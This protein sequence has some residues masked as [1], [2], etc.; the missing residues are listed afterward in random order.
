[1][2]I[3]THHEITRI[4]ELR[5]HLIRELQ[6]F[7][8]HYDE[9]E[10]KKLRIVGRARLRQARRR[11]RTGIRAVSRRAPM[12]SFGAKSLRIML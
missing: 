6:I 7:F 3:H 1:M 8:R 10:G 5:E 12:T 11:L 2:P 4:G 9:M